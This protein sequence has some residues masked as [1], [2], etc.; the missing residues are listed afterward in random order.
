M[1]SGEWRSIDSHAY[2]SD[3]KTR[4]KLT[5]KCTQKYLLRS[6]SSLEVNWKDRIRILNIFPKMFYEI[7]DEIYENFD[8]SFPS[9]LPS[10]VK[11]TKNF[12]NK[13][14]KLFWVF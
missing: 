4:S 9:N 8:K 12:E 10:R 14:A 13:K 2:L 7:Y 6:E 11:I 1:A 5:S 3:T